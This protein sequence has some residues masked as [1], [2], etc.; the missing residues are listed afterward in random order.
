MDVTD[1]PQHIGMILSEEVRH[2]AAVGKHLAVLNV[3][4]E[5]QSG[6]EGGLPWK[7]RREHKAEFS[8]D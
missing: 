4:D 3:D 1:I 5:D 7:P 8:A 2:V 6:G